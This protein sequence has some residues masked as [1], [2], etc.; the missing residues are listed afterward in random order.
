MEAIMHIDTTFHDIER[1]ATIPTAWDRWIAN[2]ERIAGHNLDGDEYEG[3][4][5]SVDGAHD[6][7]CAGMSAS[8]YVAGINRRKREFDRK[9]R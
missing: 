8:L 3:D 9:A 2:A 6:A 4:G 1:S 5:Y 7:F